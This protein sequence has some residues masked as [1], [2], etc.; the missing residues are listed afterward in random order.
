MRRP[1]Y[2]AL[3]AVFFALAVAGAVLPGL[4]TTPFILLTSYCLV[5]SSPKLHARLLASRRFG[6]L[7]ENWERRRAVTRRTKWTALIAAS[8]MIGASVLFG[9]FPPL[10]RALLVAVG[11]IGIFVVARL[12]VVE[13]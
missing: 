1:V 5:R 3:G 11:A 6:P 13:D 2:L 8:A 12:P 10:G 7:L 4:P 9:G